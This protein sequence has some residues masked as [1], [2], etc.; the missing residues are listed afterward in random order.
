MIKSDRRAGERPHHGLGHAGVPRSRRHNGG[1][2]DNQHVVRKT[3]FSPVTRTAND[4]AID[5]AAF[6]AGRRKGE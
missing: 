4:F 3:R 5:A 2:L 1:S 6:C